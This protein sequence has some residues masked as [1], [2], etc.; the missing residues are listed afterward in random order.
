VNVLPV[1]RTLSRGDGLEPSPKSENQLSRKEQ[2]HLSRIGSLLHYNRDTTLCGQGEQAR[3][4]YLVAEGVVRI[5]RC[6]GA[7]HRQIMAFRVA[8]DLCGIPDGGS[9]FNSAETV[10]QVRAYRFEWKQMQ[11]VFLDDP[12]MRL[13]LLGK[14]LYDYRQAEDRILILGQQNTCQRLAS[15][16]LDFIGIAEFFEEDRGCVMLPVN[17][18]DLADYLG[19]TPESISRSFLKLESMGLI[20]R[21]TARRVELLDLPGLRLLKSTPRRRYS[22]RDYAGRQP[23][24]LG[25]DGVLGGIERAACETLS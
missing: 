9:Y 17:R 24:R 4:L 19:T 11:D 6:D 10:S 25:L 13:V 22:G 15:C 1:I 20:R 7:G 23:A 18:F 16:M 5:T 2:E 21:L 8:G 3:F 12:H 14:I